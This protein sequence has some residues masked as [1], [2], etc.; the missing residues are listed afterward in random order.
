VQCRRTASSAFLYISED[1]QLGLTLFVKYL[2]KVKKQ[3]QP[4]YKIL[5]LVDESPP[6]QASIINKLKTLFYI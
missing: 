1:S 5:G 6:P 3:A 2:K 4:H